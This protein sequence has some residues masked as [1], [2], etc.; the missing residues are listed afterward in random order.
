MKIIANDY[1]ANEVFR[2]IRENSGKSQKEFGKQI[3]RSTTAIQYYEYGERNYDFE[4]LLKIAK[5]ENLNSIIE[6][7]K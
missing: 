3:N 4:L 1:R 7:K 2:I 5:K 6:S